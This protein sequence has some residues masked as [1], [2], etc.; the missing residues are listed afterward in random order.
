MK[1]KEINNTSVKNHIAFMHKSEK[2]RL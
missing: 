1:D 2:R